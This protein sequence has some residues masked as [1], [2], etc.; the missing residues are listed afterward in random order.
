MQYDVVKKS[1]PTDGDIKTVIIS[2]WS[3]LASSDP[4]GLSR[5]HICPGLHIMLLLF[6]CT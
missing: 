3:T 5:L 2:D 1:L 6:T 4:S